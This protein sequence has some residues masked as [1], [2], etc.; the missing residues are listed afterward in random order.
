[1]NKVASSHVFEEFCQGQRPRQF[2]LM[3]FNLK[4]THFQKW[5]H[6]FLSFCLSDCPT[7]VTLD[8][9]EMGY[10]IESL[11]LL[12][13]GKSATNWW[14]VVVL[15]FFASCAFCTRLWEFPKPTQLILWHTRNLVH[16]IVSCMN[17]SLH[18]DSIYE[19]ELPECKKNMLQITIG[20]FKH[21]L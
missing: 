8:A 13:C 7:S 21:V 9:P 12:W 1:M 20:L 4:D 10:W 6:L 17:W 19:R 15:Q 2:H 16:L 14:T 3:A 5:R 11:P 18:L